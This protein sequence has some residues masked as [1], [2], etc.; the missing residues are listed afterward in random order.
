M[1]PFFRFYSLVDRKFRVCPYD[2]LNALNVCCNV[3]FLSLTFIN[4]HFSLHLLTDLTLIFSKNKV[5]ISLI[6]C[7]CF[8]SIDFSPELDCFW[9]LIL[10]RFF[11][12]ML[13]A[14]HSMNLPLRTAFIV[15]HRF[16]ML[17]IYFHSILKCF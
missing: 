5:F 8:Y 14:L 6:F 1:P 16:G 10:P 2:S 9:P 7:I 4:F 12:F 17:Y 3:S 11:F 15:Y 13:S